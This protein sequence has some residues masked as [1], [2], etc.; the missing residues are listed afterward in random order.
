VP[1]VHVALPALNES[2]ALPATI[3]SLLA[4]THHPF[5]IWVCVNQPDHWWVEDEKLDICSDNQITL[6]YLKKLAHP[7]IRILDHSSPGHGWTGKAYGVG[8]ARRVTMEAIHEHAAAEDLI[9]SADAD[10]YYPPGYLASVVQSFS[11]HP[12]AMA[13]ANPYYHK[14]SGDA[15]LD[16]AML[17]Y[18]IYMRCFALNMWRIGSPYSF[19]AL[20]SAIALPI[21][22]YRKTGGITAKKSGEDFYFLQKLRKTGWILTHNDI[23]VNPG[24][25]FSD[26]VFFGTGPALIKGSQGIWD[27]YPVYDYRLFDRVRE[28]YDI[29]PALYYHDVST[30]MD[31]FLIKQL[32]EKVFQPLRENAASQKQFIKACHHKIDGLRILQFLKSEQ[33]SES[34]SNEENLFQFLQQ[35]YPEFVIAQTEHDWNSLDFTTTSME[36]LN[37]I[38]NFL[39]ETERIYQKTEA[40]GHKRT[41]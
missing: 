29:F 9:V 13:L 33:A 1:C 8:Q 39:F 4:Q 41:S 38:R 21:R 6:A 25:R 27:S 20:G 14:R 24:T 7:H 19:S 31:A 23:I 35:F 15:L 5:L 26:R 2:A 40:D 16:R 11:S 22:A 37:K 18:E 36:F 34:Y 3:N 32:G 28:T 12:H 10:T 30:P 17:R